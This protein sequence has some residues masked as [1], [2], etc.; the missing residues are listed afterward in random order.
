LKKFYSS[1]ALANCA[2]CLMLFATTSISGFC[3]A[4]VINTFSPASG[5]VGTL[6]TI[7][8]SN[9][10]NPLSLTIGG[11]A[12]IPVSNSGTQLVALVMP[13]TTT[14][15]V[16]IT[17]SGGGPANSSTN[18]TVTT[19]TPPNGQ[20]GPKLDG[21]DSSGPAA[22]GN[23]VAISADGNTVLF[24]G[25]KDGTNQ[26]AAW[27]FT[28]TGTSWTQQGSKLVGTG[29][30]GAAGEGYSVG[31]SA[32][33]NTAILG[34]YLDNSFAGAA[35]VFT[36]NGSTWSQQGNKLVANDEK[37]SSYLGHSVALSADGNTA[38][39]GGF[40]DS[41]G[42]GAAWIFTRSGTTW[43]QQGGKLVGTGGTG[44]SYQ[45]YSVGLSADGNTAIIGGPDDNSA[46][47][48][49]WIFTRSGSTWTQEGSKLVGSGNTGAAYQGVSVALSADGNTAIIGGSQ[50]NSFNGAAWVFTRSGSVWT[51]QGSKLAG[52]GN[53]G[54]AG[55]GF[56]VSIS[57]DGNIAIVGG[58]SDN[59][60]A[61]ASWIFTRS[62]SS[63]SQHGNKL[64][65]S[66]YKGDASQGNSVGISADGMTAVVG[67]LND[68]S[69]EGAAWIY[70]PTGS[71]PVSLISMDGQ[72]TGFIN[73]INWTTAYE[74]SSDYF[75]VERSIDGINYTEVG[76]V[77][78]ADN[79]ALNITYHYSDNIS[80]VT[81]DI[82]YYRLRLVD[83]SGSVSYSG[84]IRIDLGN[85]EFRA[86][87]SP[88]PF[89]DNLRV[90]IEDPTQE[91]AELTVKDLNGKL[92]GQMNIALI[93]GDNSIF[94]NEIDNSP[95]G[96]YFITIKTPTRLQTIKILKQ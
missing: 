55:Q 93:K 37:G 95:G 52:T 92:V 47:G 64:V 86:V 26:G 68:N 29:N 58:G 22:Q 79:S 72:N 84:T 35:W 42:T 40:L 3:Q 44:A 89:T 27:V 77:K 61:G 20:Q 70:V 71:L 73:T 21:S 80:S 12:A 38:I 74:E 75:G 11:I 66:D 2:T 53:T 48:A 94:I 31:L 18:F 49:A 33:G 85:S 81:S 76:T 9:L 91:P 6:V 51:Q 83:L 41:T 50:D 4:P 54:A 5:T 34:G 78:A 13:G 30:S 45:G 17:T 88:N 62:G 36:R 65:A 28:R 59:L 60:S 57:A 43:T 16:S 15:I 8:G 69:G 90:N 46:Q 39:I 23:A 19:S 1:K 63:W 10:N 96:I 67:G 14:G 24:G 7:S 32:D 87:V 25:Y 56:A 82:Y